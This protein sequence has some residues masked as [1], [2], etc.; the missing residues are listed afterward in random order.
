MTAATAGI[1]EPSPAV[2]KPKHKLSELT[3]YEL[4]DYRHALEQAIA[5]GGSPGPGAPDRTVLPARLDAVIAE[6]DDRARIARASTG[7]DIDEVRDGPESASPD[8]G[9]QGP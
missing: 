6:Q 7:P 3:T 8:S 2:E 5:S 4:R 9:R 1:M